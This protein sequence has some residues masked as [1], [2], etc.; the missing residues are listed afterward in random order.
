[1][2]VCGPLIGVTSARAVYGA[3]EP[4]AAPQGHDLY[5]D[6]DTKDVYAHRKGERGEAVG[7]G[8]LLDPWDYLKETYPRHKGPQ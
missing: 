6:P 8:E 5:R 1:M 7:E 3:P 2:L 4:R